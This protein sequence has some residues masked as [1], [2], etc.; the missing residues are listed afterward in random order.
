MHRSGHSNC[1]GPCAPLGFWNDHRA[2][3]GTIINIC[4]AEEGASMGPQVEVWMHLV[5]SVNNY[6]S[7]SDNISYSRDIAE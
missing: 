7:V 2:Q 5:Y 3:E 4:E 6:V 1:V